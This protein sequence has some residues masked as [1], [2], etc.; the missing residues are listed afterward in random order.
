MVFCDRSDRTSE[1]VAL[2]EKHGFGHLAWPERIG[3]NANAGEAL[4]W[5]FDIGAAYTVFLEDDI[6]PMRDMLLWFEW[7]ER[8]R[9]D[10]KVFTVTGYNQCPDGAID[11]H[12]F[13]EWFHAWGFATW[14]DRWEEFRWTEKEPFPNTDAEGRHQDA[15]AYLQQIRKSRVEAYPCISRV[16]NIG[17]IDGWHVNSPDWHAEHHRSRETSGDARVEEFRAV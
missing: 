8:F 12:R 13:Q 6:V 2:A 5:A 14:R 3:G 17:A 15:D 10:P 16:Q 4:A 1:C 11:E 9:S 7:A